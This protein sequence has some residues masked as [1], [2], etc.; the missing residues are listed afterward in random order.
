VAGGKKTLLE[1]RRVRVGE[2][3]ITNKT[4]RVKPLLVALKLCKNLVANK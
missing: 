3:N 1:M 4:M 2:G